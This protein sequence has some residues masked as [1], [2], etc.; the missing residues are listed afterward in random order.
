M[1]EIQLLRSREQNKHSHQTP[2]RDQQRPKPSTITPYSIATMESY[3]LDLETQH[4]NTIKIVDQF[5]VYRAPYKHVNN[6]PIYAFFLVPKV[7]PAGPRPLMVR[8][9][10]GGWTEGEAEASLRPFLLEMTRD[11]GAV[12]VAPDYRLRPEHELADGVQDSRDFWRWVEDGGAQAC[13]ASTPA[14][15][16]VV[17]DASNVAVAGESAGGYHTAQVALLGMTSLPIKCLIIQYPALMVGRKLRDEFERDEGSS[18]PIFAEKVPYSV[19]E[20]HLAGLEPGHVCSRAP[21]AARMDLCAALMQAGKMANVEGENA[22]LDPWVSLET[23]GK[24]PPILL[25]H[26]KEDEA[27][28]WEDTNEWAAKLKRLQPDVPLYL[29]FQTGSHVFDVNHTTR[30]PWLKEPLE[31]VSKYWPA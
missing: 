6:R 24:L 14:T 25:Y 4:P 28:S 8:Y 27:V 9:H 5:N 20:K 2:I 22:Y 11:S 15:A 18:R 10:G 29:S 16:G 31:F 30:E 12:L 23:A 21:F 13:L 26:S 7:L 1:P 19:V 3:K 17:L